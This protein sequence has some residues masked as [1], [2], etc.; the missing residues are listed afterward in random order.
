[1]D[2][3]TLVRPQLIFQHKNI[4]GRD[5][6]HV[7]IGAVRHVT[8]IPR[9]G[10]VCLNTPPFLMADAIWVECNGKKGKFSLAEFKSSSRSQCITCE[11][12]IFSPSA[13]EAFSGKGSAKKWRLSI[14]YN[15]RPI[16]DYLTS[17]GLF[18]GKRK[19]NGTSE[20]ADTS[21]LDMNG[22]AKSKPH[23]GTTA[24]ISFGQKRVSSPSRETSTPK[25]RQ[26]SSEST[27]KSRAGSS[28]A[29]DEE[30][31][32]PNPQRPARGLHV[33]VRTYVWN[34]L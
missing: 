17:L 16:D 2:T 20:E 3:N 9:F 30:R 23:G 32:D 15:G 24:G 27:V 22:R 8:G 21:G 31:E 12:K 11:G 13:F 4:A 10:T 26:M 25:R 34:V 14:K 29:S 33:E 6:A 7:H 28:A 5:K 18:S 1:M 19:L